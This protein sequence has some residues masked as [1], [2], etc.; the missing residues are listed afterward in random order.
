MKASEFFNPEERKQIEQA[1]LKAELNTSGEIRV[2][3]EIS[4]R[5]K[6][7][8]RAAT[9]FARL[10]MHKTALRNG[11][12]FYLSVKN[13]KFAVIGDTGINNVV[14]VNFWDE[15][16]AVMEDHFRNSQFAEGLSKGVMMAGEQMKKNFPYQKDDVDELPDEISFG[17]I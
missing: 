11:V 15:I 6:L 17:K 4:F 12:L 3:V 10:G 9:V 14:P 5:G 13:R 1:I 8:D 7:L 2:H 16:R